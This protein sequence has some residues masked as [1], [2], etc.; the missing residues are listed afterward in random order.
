MSWG[1][2]KYQVNII[3]GDGNQGLQLAQPRQ[4]GVPTYS[5][6]FFSI[7][8]GPNDP[9]CYTVEAEEHMKVLH[10][11]MKNTL[12]LAPTRASCFCSKTC[13]TSQPRPAQGSQPKRVKAMRIVA[14]CQ[15]VTGGMQGWTWRSTPITSTIKTTWIMWEN[16]SFQVNET[17]LLSDRNIFGRHLQILM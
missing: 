1:C 10:R 17:C 3:P 9:Y 2:V 16:F 7:L 5:A 13:A 12:F 15:C 6:A 8:D 4:G 11:C 14:L